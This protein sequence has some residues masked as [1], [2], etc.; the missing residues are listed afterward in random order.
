MQDG[1]S[2]EECPAELLA[3]RAYEDKLLEERLAAV[4]RRHNTPCQSAQSA[5]G[6]RSSS[7]T[8]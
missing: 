4:A 3:I 6:T 7:R 2:T 5:D 8:S 1:G